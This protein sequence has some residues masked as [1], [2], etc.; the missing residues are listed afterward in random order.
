MFLLRN[1]NNNN[2][3]SGRQMVNSL[4]GQSLIGLVVELYRCTDLALVASRCRNTRNSEMEQGEKV[5][6][7]RKLLSRSCM[8]YAAIMY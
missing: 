8:L 1:N 3:T 7:L 6:A 4:T 5:K 2:N